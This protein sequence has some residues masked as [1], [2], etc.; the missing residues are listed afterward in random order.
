MV[1]GLYHHLLGQGAVFTGDDEE[2]DALR[3][4]LHGVG[5]GPCVIVVVSLEVVNQ[6]APHVVY[7]DVNDAAERG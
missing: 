6:V 3:A 1:L 7:L 2:V 5:D 4:S